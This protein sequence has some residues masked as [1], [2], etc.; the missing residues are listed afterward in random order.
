MSDNDFGMFTNNPKSIQIY[1]LNLFESVAK[2]YNHTFR[3]YL[4]A[5]GMRAFIVNK[6]NISNAIYLLREVSTDPHYV[7]SVLRKKEFRCRISPKTENP[8]EHFAITKYLTT[9]GKNLPTQ[10]IEEFIEFHDSKTKAFSEFQ[11]V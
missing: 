10:E 9:I 5:H 11:L 6:I 1:Y 2:K 8:P 4:T 3:I 7:M